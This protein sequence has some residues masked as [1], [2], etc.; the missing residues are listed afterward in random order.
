MQVAND[1]RAQARA[2]EG[3]HL[4][5][6]MM[7]GTARSMV[8]GA[9]TIEHLLKASLN[10][11]LDPNEA[12]AD[13]RLIAGFMLDCNA[14]GRDAATENLIRGIKAEAARRKLLRGENDR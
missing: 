13:N 2:L 5:G 10:R 11:D 12:A 14:I 9:A 7:D 4:A 3:R 1:L 6:T 8:R